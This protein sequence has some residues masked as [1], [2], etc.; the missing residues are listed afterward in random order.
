MPVYDS[1]SMRSPRLSVF[2]STKGDTLMKYARAT[3]NIALCLLIAMPFGC[4]Q[5]VKIRTRRE[6]GA[7][8]KEIDEAHLIG[9]SPKEV[10]KFLDSR[11]GFDHRDYTRWLPDPKERRTF[12]AW[13]KKD[14]GS[15]IHPTWLVAV[16]CVY[17]TFR[18]D[19]AN[20]LTGYTVEPGFRGGV[21]S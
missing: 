14:L 19:E 10:I 12:D 1:L 11:G 13:T 7:V 8:R 17:I 21:D 18:F 20:R 3:L 6:A 9:A 5:S 16:G 15:V 2:R 4:R